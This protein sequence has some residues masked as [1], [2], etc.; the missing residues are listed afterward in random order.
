MQNTQTSLPSPFLRFQP[1]PEDESIDLLERYLNLLA[2]VYGLRMIALV[3]TALEINKMHNL[4]RLS[5]KRYCKRFPVRLQD[6]DF[7]LFS[8]LVS[9]RFLT[10]DYLHQTLGGSKAKLEYG[11]LVRLAKHR[12]LG[13]FEHIDGQKVVV[14]RKKGAQAYAIHFKK[15]IPKIDYDRRFKKYSKNGQVYALKQLYLDHTLEINNDEPISRAGIDELKNYT[16]LFYEK[17]LDIGGNVEEKYKLKAPVYRKRTLP[18]GIITRVRVGYK[19]TDIDVRQGVLHR[20]TGQKI[21]LPK[22]IDCS[23]EADYSSFVRKKIKTLWLWCVEVW[24]KDKQGFD[25]LKIP[26]TTVSHERRDNLCRA[27]SEAIP[28]G[29]GFFWFACRKDFDHCRPQSY[30]T[31]PIWKCPKYKKFHPLFSPPML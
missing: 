2:V 5:R 10:I 7:K 27:V 3:N 18:N 23:T 19:A 16:I 1:K 6:R 9:G 8:L 22:E 4:K 30:Y 21:L 25:L 15:E 20:P 13:V 31:A 11:R 14:L 26:I 28:N 24:K 12:Y 17:N 29:L